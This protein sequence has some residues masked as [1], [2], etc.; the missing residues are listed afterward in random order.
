MEQVINEFK[1]EA[2]FSGV[3]L[4]RQGADIILEEN[5]GMAHRGFLVRNNIHTMFDVASVTKVF[6]ATAILQLVEKG[7]LSLDDK[8][9]DILDL[10]Q[11]KIP[12]NVSI[13]HL[14]SHTSGIADDAEEELGENY[15]DLFINTP[16]Y[17]YRTLA[18]YLPNFIYK[19]PNFS[20]GTKC[21]YNNCAYILLGLVTEKLTGLN[22]KEYLNNNVFGP[23]G[24]NR[25]K[26]CAMDEINENTAE[27]YIALKNEQHE[28]IGWKKNIY[29]YPPVGGTDGGVYTTAY[30]LDS[31][32][33]NVHGILDKDSYKQLFSP[34]CEFKR[35][36]TRW[37]PELN[38]TIRYGY[39]FEFVEIGQKIFCIRKDGINEGVSAMLSY[40]PEYDADIIVLSNQGD[41]VW[42]L[43]RRLQ[44]VLYESI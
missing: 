34:Q 29:S 21:M 41:N 43:H 30:D 35:P 19:E 8:I 36:F 9:T 1:D 7:M 38:A 18:D 13:K 14:L 26:F 11:S 12:S 4:V 16:N 31:F 23:C 27:N 44:T 6:T 28:I 25:T 39:G 24:M 2:G 10:S 32:I 40:Y 5:S 3:C 15:S 20:A 22:Y 37:K 42:E 17:K 33:R